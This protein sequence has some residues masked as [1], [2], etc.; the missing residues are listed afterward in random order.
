LIG[1]I[2][3]LD[4]LSLFTQKYARIMGG[5]GKIASSR[6]ST[7]EGKHKLKGLGIVGEEAP[8]NRSPKKSN[9][10]SQN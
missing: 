3:D 5:M 9:R 8:L 10:C 4:L 1:R 7:M 6:R 2:V